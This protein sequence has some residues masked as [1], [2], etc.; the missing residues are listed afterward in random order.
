V[1]EENKII[2]R[3]DSIVIF[4]LWIAVQTS[5]LMSGANA[6]VDWFELTKPII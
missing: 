3:I 4:W 6:K 5:G 1:V 2:K